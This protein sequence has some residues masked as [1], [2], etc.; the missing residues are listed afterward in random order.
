MLSLEICFTTTSSFS[1]VIFVVKKLDRYMLKPL[2]IFVVVD[3]QNCRIIVIIQLY[4]PI[5][6]IKYGQLSNEV[7]EPNN[8]S[9]GRK[10]C[11]K[12]RLHGRG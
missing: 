2:E 9:S 4:E 10:A 6:K 7:L 1:T 12:L 11:Y 8:L 5:H 3:K